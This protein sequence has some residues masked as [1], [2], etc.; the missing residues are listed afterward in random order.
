MKMARNKII[1]K[2]CSKRKQIKGRNLRQGTN[3]IVSWQSSLVSNKD[4]Q[5][6]LG[7]SSNL[8]SSQNYNT[9]DYKRNPISSNNNIQS[10]RTNSEIV[11]KR[12]VPLHHLKCYD[13]AEK[14]DI[15]RANDITSNENSNPEYWDFSSGHDLNQ[16]IHQNLS[17]TIL[18]PCSSEYT[19]TSGDDTET[20]VIMPDDCN[21]IMNHNFNPT[22]NC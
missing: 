5:R 17:V 8:Q 1:K 9:I 6:D 11:L 3:K 20:S 19:A 12:T 13:W 22:L 4:L 18:K 10:W 14:M 2:K 15:E 21:S 7:N 16:N